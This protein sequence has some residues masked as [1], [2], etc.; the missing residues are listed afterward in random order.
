[1]SPRPKEQILEVCLS[2]WEQAERAL[3]KKNASD[4]PV[5]L[6]T[7]LQ[8]RKELSGPRLTGQ[9][10]GCSA[11]NDKCAGQFLVTLQSECRP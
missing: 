4:H 11:A 9:Q 7:G 3:E 10:I 6:G 8:V 2:L 1:M 5:R